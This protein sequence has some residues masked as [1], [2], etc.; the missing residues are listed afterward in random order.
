MGGKLLLIA[1]SLVLAGCGGEATPAP[2]H[3]LE[4]T[5]TIETRLTAA[6]RAAIFDAVWQTVNDKY[7]DPSFGGKDWQAIGDEYRFDPSFGGKDWQAIGD[8]YRQ[9]LA[10]VQDDGTF[11]FLVANPM[12]FELGV[13]HIGALP[14]ELSNELDS[15]T[16]ATGS[17]GMDV[18]L[19]DGMA[20][21]IQVIEGSPADEAGLRPG[22]VVTS[23]D[24]R[25]PSDFPDLQTPPDNERNRRRNGV[26][27][28][29]SAL[30]GEVG[31]EVVIEYLDA[32]DQTQRTTLQLPNSIYPCRRP[33]QNLR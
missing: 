29:R 30:Y 14:S 6:E 32:N 3:T 25:T 22:F 17:L 8:E 12:L 21:V 16:F 27:G 5:I 2:T 19:M 20:V 9:Q 15:I 18:R 10:T 4:P 31:T 23:V 24:G 28:I 26:S 7:F 33:A 11:W 1:F 13:S